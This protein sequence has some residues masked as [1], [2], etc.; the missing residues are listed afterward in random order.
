MWKG[1]VNNFRLTNILAKLKALDKWLSNRLRYCIW[2][3]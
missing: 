3:D 1:W 2:H